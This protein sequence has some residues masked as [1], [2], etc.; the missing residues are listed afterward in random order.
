MMTKYLALLL[1]AATAVV[2][3]VDGLSSPV[4]VAELA[5]QTR[6]RLQTALYSPSGKLTLSPEVVIPEPSDP[7]ALLLQ[8]SVVTKLS[9]D[10]RIRAK[11]NAAFVSGSLM[12][13]QQMAA[14]QE[15]ARGSFPG[16]LPVIFCPGVGQELDEDDYETLAESGSCA[17]LT[18]VPAD[19]RAVSSVDELHEEGDGESWMEEARSL[20]LHPIP[21]VVLSMERSWSEEDVVDLVS[22][23]RTKYG[24][25]A[26][27]GDGMDGPVFVVLSMDGAAELQTSS[28]TDDDDD[29]DDTMTTT[30]NEAFWDHVPTLPKSLVARTPVLG[31]VRMGNQDGLKEYNARLKAKGFAGA[32]LRA[33]CVPGFRKNPDLDFVGKFWSAIIA[34]LKSTRSKTFDGF[35]TKTA[36]DKDV[37]LEWLNYQKDI[38]SSGALGESSAQSNIDDLDLDGGDHYGF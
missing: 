37:P 18:S 13:V 9:T 38:M 15:E 4:V 21:E 30:T 11:A 6:Y 23:L 24:H 27:D 22:V 32:F 28:E 5:A 7:T 20:G 2:V 1:A 17:I 14:E 10:L 31:S 12:S 8:S 33:D 36:L 26:D 25:P 34:N 19:G 16:P 35:R 29:G 3:T